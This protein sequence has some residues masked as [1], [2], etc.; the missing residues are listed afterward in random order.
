M[1]NGKVFDCGHSPD[2]RL[3]NAKIAEM[4]EMKLMQNG[5]LR[6][7]FTKLWVPAPIPMTNV[8]GITAPLFAD[9]Y[10]NVNAPTSKIFYKGFY[11]ERLFCCFM[12]FY[13]VNA[14]FHKIFWRKYCVQV[15]KIMIFADLKWCRQLFTLKKRKWAFLLDTKSKTFKNKAHFWSKVH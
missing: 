9:I 11:Y 14:V 13:F 12:Y 4:L 2:R 15:D 5:S 7:C 6:A 8:M 3:L 1:R 10:G